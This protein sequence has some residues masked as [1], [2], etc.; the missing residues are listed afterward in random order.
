VASLDDDF[1]V[2]DEP[3]DGEEEYAAS[4][5]DC[6]MLDNVDEEDCLHGEYDQVDMEAIGGFRNTNDG[7]IASD[8]EMDSADG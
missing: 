6:E 2:D 8:I 7:A 3:D 5:D 4:S 1:I